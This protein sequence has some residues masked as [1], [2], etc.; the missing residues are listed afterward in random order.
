MQAVLDRRPK[1]EPNGQRY[2]YYEGG[3]TALTTL[4]TVTLIVG[5]ALV[6]ARAASVATNTHA[7]VSTKKMTSI[8]PPL[9]SLGRRL[10]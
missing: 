9:P 7:M 10:L 3:R 4:L 6:V 1:E 2:C 8:I 5:E